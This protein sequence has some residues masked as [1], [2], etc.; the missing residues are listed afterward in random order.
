M[1]YKDDVRSGD[2]HR[3]TH[4]EE[5]SSPLGKLFVS[6]KS[7]PDGCGLCCC[8][9]HQLTFKSNILDSM[10]LATLITI[11]DG[12]SFFFSVAVSCRT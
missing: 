3:S 12:H 6:G 4:D 5:H 7:Q 8:D 2:S 9:V 1:A 10:D 11:Q